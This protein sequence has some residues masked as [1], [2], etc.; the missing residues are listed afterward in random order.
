MGEYHNGVQSDRKL[1]CSFIAMV[2]LGVTIDVRKLTGILP[3]TCNHEVGSIH[4][5]KFDKILRGNI[6]NGPMRS[7]VTIKMMVPDPQQQVTRLVTFKVGP[8]VIHIAGLKHL[9]FAWQITYC[10]FKHLE[11]LQHDM[12]RCSTEE[13]VTAATWLAYSSSPAPTEVT[14]L[15]MCGQLDANTVPLVMPPAAP[16]G[17][18]SVLVEIYK[19]PIPN[20]P[21]WAAYIDFLKYCVTGNCIFTGEMTVLKVDQ[22]NFI[23]NYPLG[24][25]VDRLTLASRLNG[26]AGFVADYVDTVRNSVRA[27]I[28]CPICEEVRIREGDRNEKK[29]TFTINLTGNIVHSSPC[30]VHADMARAHFM[31][32]LRNI[33]VI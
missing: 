15:A 14:Q 20:F 26:V 1:V 9:D 5:V 33:G 24:R 3:I 27:S 6:G 10:F 30:D 8:S 7:M 21:S 31:E 32:T 28:L 16:Q 23:Y 13:H 29:H 11:A 2:R 19:R 4:G 12:I 22:A 25:P 17:I 18:D